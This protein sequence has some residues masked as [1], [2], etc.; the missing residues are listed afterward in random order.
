MD[1]LE[2]LKWTLNKWRGEIGRLKSVK[3]DDPEAWKWTIKTHW[4]VKVDGLK[5]DDLE[6]FVK[7][8]TIRILEI[9]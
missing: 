5:V 1:S 3:V 7:G 8:T 4:S 9:R 6:I 2:V